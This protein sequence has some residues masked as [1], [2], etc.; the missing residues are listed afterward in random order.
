ML[1]SRT[2]GRPLPEIPSKDISESLR[3]R[4]NPGFHDGVSNSECRVGFQDGGSNYNSIGLGSRA[5]A[6]VFNAIP[7]VVDLFEAD[8]VV[9]T[10]AGHWSG[11]TS[12]GCS[13]PTS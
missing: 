10:G 2:R 4:Q 9:S 7:L 3:W 8:C 5:Q 13:I 1:F 11:D 6:Q 12:D